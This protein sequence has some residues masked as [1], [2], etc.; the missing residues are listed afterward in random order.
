MNVKQPVWG[1]K[2]QVSGVRCD[3]VP[4]AQ[5][6]ASGIESRTHAFTLIELLTVI[7]IIGI[8]AALLAPSLTQ[9][10]KPNAIVAASRQMLDD[11]ARA[12]QLAIANRTTVYMVF[13][14]QNITTLPQWSTLFS[15]QFASTTVTQMYNAQL[16][17]YVLMSLR[18][19]GDQPGRDHPR[20]LSDVTIL[21]DGSFIGTN[22]FIPWNQSFDVY[23]GP[24]TGYRIYGFLTSSNLPF[25]VVGVVTNQNY[26]FP[27][28]SH[29]TV[30]YIAFNYL[31]QLVDD[32]GNTLY[33]SRGDE[34]IPLAQGSVL[35]PRNNTTK[36]PAPG[37]TSVTENPPGNSTNISYNLIHIDALTGRARLE[38]E[39]VK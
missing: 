15:Q 32:S 6:Q 30:P 33:Q 2:C 14:P 37:A 9:W 1:A 26:A 5:C 29:I 13:I 38:H 24:P 7:A 21:P 35:P 16:R 19:V 17:G 10:R 11:V 20:H 23:G 8:I 27:P 18:D 12:R 28:K 22:K 34:Y 36:A 4:G 39:E 3:Q 31:G 25:P